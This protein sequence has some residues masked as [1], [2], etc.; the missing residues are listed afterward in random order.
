MTQ[1]LARASKSVQLALDENN[2]ASKVVELPSSTRTAL[3][4]ANSI[5][6]TIEQIAKSLIFKTKDTN[7]PVLILASGPNRVNEKTI[8]FH[9]GEKIVKADADFVR[10]ATGFAIG[11][12]PPIGHRTKIENIFIDEDLLKYE[13][14][15]AAAGTPNSVFSMRNPDLLKMTSGKVISVK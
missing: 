2:I 10:E 8:E 15:W 3:D 1:T 11:G 4:A 7:K 13:E 9:L 5:G 12:I 6:C 14:L